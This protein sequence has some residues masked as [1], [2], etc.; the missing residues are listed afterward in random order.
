MLLQLPFVYTLYNRSKEVDVER[1]E[2]TGMSEENT[3]HFISEKDPKWCKDADWSSCGECNVSFTFF[4][5]KHHCRVCG[6]IFCDDCAPTSATLGVRVCR[7]CSALIRKRFGGDDSKIASLVKDNGPSFSSVLETAASGA[8]VGL[9]VGVAVLHA[10]ITL[11]ILGAG[12]AGYAAQRTDSIGVMARKGGRGVHK[13]ARV[14]GKALDTGLQGAKKIDAKYGI[15]DKT[16]TVA[17]GAV[18]AIKKGVTF[19]S[20]KVSGKEPGFDDDKEDENV[21]SKSPDE[22]SLLSPFE[23]GVEPE[24]AY[25]DTAIDNITGT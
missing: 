17:V 9:L 16:A 8:G 12:T 10:P 6:Q 22:Q 7:E 24:F 11:A 20:E 14:T 5:R 23:R 1:R 3:I 21:S 19:V 13:V 2:K 25:E 18:S 15:T 4:N